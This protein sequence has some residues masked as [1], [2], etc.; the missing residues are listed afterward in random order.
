MNMRIFL[1]FF[2]ILTFSVQATNGISTLPS[3]EWQ[4]NELE[5]KVYNKINRGVNVL[6]NH[7]HFFVDVNISISEA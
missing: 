3:L 4:K 5:S 2:Y 1:I 6:L 7:D